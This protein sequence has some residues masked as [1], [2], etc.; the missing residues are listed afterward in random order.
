MVKPYPKPVNKGLLNIPTIVKID[1]LQVFDLSGKMVHQELSL[2]TNKQI[3]LSELN[4]GVYIIQFV[5][6]QFNESKKIVIE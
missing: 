5:S 1:K 2:D 6:S 4:K 3:D